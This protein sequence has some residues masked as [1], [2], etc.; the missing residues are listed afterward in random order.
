MLKRAKQLAQ[1]VS[2]GALGASLHKRQIMSNNNYS[3]DSIDYV[4]VYQGTAMNRP[5]KVQVNICGSNTSEELKVL[6]T[7]LV[8][9]DTIS[10]SDIV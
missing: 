6:Y 10:I 9:F 8:A 1:R 3:E 7:G 4:V 5:S 2:A